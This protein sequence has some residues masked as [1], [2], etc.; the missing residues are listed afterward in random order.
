MRTLIINI[1]RVISSQKWCLLA[2]ILLS[3]AQNGL[4]QPEK[5]DFSQL[6]NRL[7]PRLIEAS[8]HIQKQVNIQYGVDRENKVV[9]IVVSS[10]ITKSSLEVVTRFRFV[11]GTKTG[12]EVFAYILHNGKQIA[13]PDPEQNLVH[14]T[15]TSVVRKHFKPITE[16]DFLEY[17]RHAKDVSVEGMNRYFNARMPP[18]RK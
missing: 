6:Q 8:D 11:D 5:F 15:K 9:Y 3:I 18:A 12:K 1:V 13:P 4:S 2:S 16:E 10:W 14:L 7:S 17:L